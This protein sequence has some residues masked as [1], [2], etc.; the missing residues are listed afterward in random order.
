MPRFFFDIDD[1]VKSYEGDDAGVE[2]ADA[3]VARR[4]AIATLAEVAVE[5]LPDGDRHSLKARVRDESERL[6][7]EATLTLDGGWVV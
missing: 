5:V 4:E 6:I 7:Y 2:L 1:G 3:E